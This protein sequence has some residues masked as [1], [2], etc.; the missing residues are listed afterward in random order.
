M[1]NAEAADAQYMNSSLAAISK[2]QLQLY[3]PVSKMMKQWMTHDI[4]HFHLHNE[5]D[6]SDTYSKM[7]QQYSYV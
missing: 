2:S 7:V 5:A 1:A 6:H 4:V 3:L